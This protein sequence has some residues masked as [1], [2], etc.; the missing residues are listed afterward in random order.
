MQPIRHQQSFEESPFE[1]K[2]VKIYRCAKVVKGGRRFRFAALVIVGDRNGQVGVG[3]GKANQVPAAVDKGIK[4]ARKNVVQVSLKGNTIPHRVL[5]RYGAARVIMVPAREGT[6]VIAGV[7]LRPLL[8]LAGVRDVLT[9]S[10]G[11][12]NPKNLLLAGLRGLMQ[13]RT[14]EQV[15]KLRGVKVE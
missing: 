12:S 7:H 14:G 13:L 5:A 8:E 2:V 9:K 3:Y 6:G 15:S 11:S 1:E 4:N 10:I